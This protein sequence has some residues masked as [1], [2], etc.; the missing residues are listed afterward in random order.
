MPTLEVD[1]SDVVFV[2]KGRGEAPG[3]YHELGANDLLVTMQVIASEEDKRSHRVDPIRSC[4]C[5]WY[6]DQWV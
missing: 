5:G 6:S 2:V 4:L 1:D 3:G